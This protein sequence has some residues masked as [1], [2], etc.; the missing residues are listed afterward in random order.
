MEV[1]HRP[2]HGQPTTCLPGEDPEIPA[3]GLIAGPS[4]RKPSRTEA[5]D[6]RVGNDIDLLIVFLIRL[7]RRRQKSSKPAMNDCAL[8]R[9]AKPGNTMVISDG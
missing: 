3:R 2:P 5:R 6:R 4:S 1:E 7:I 9:P 8:I